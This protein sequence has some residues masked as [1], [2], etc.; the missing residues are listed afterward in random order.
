MI[1]QVAWSELA[2]GLM[3]LAPSILAPLALFANGLGL[4]MIWGLVFG[5]LEGRRLS[6]V[7][8]AM[9]CASFI[10]ASGGVKSVGKVLWMGGAFRRG[11][12][13]GR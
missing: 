6:E 1:A 11:F 7:L 8:G 2:L 13:G 12:G 4:G 5:F 3:G 10:L 9:L